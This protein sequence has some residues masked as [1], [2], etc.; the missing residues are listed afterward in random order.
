MRL[1]VPKIWLGGYLLQVVDFC[2]DGRQV[3]DTPELCPGDWSVG[4]FRVLS[5]QDLTSGS[6]CQW[7]GL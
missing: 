7:G 1:I 5:R 4:R 6:G 2:L 3:K